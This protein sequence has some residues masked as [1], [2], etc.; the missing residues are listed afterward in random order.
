ML[1]KLAQSGEQW[2]SPMT[3]LMISRL[4]WEAGQ[5]QWSDLRGDY[6][7]SVSI[8]EAAGGGVTMMT[9]LHIAQ[10]LQAPY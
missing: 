9:T 1:G 6:T 3:M 7:H 2:Q 5:V 8:T 10:E 4:Q